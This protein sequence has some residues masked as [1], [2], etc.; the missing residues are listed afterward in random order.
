MKGDPWR[1]FTIPSESVL[2]GHAAV[3]KDR[4]PKLD[5]S[6]NGNFIMRWNEGMKLSDFLS[7]ISAST[8]EESYEPY[9]AGA[10]DTMDEI[11]SEDHS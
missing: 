1:I 6:R 4:I 9:D 11:F 5:T 2:K 8:F 7:F 10:P 3:L